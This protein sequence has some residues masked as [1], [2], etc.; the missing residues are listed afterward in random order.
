MGDCE[1]HRVAFSALVFASHDFGEWLKLPSDFS[2]KLQ[3]ETGIEGE[4]AP[5]HLQLEF[6]IPPTNENMY[7]N[8]ARMRN[9]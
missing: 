6:G 2:R 9:N 3:V 8:L 7:L 4:S 5:I 1:I